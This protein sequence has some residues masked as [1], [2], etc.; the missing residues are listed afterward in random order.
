MKYGLLITAALMLSPFAVS[1]QSASTTASVT[2]ENYALNITKNQDL[3]F[4]SITP[5]AS[6]A[7]TM[8][9]THNGL[10]FTTG[11]VTSRPGSGYSPAAYTIRGSPAARFSVTIEPR[12]IALSGP[13]A[14]ILVSD[15]ILSQATPITLDSTSG[16]ASFNVGAAIY[17]NAG[18]LPGNYSGTFY[19]SVAYN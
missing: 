1:A 11:G 6:A 5:S 15:F 18:Q 4:G 10:V 13:G 3:S 9:L 8:T 19:V 7:G 2:V 12:P 16:V 14:A 17:V